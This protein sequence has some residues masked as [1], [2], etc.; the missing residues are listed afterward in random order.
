MTGWV[1]QDGKRV[2]A[3]TGQRAT[4]WRARTV[5]RALD[6]KPHKIERWAT[7]KAKAEALVKA[8]CRDW[9]APAGGGAGLRGGMT[10]EAAAG[11][12][13]EHDVKRSSRAPSTIAQY[14][15]NV[16]R[17]IKGST[18]A[19]LT[20]R[21]A[22]AVGILR[23]YFQGLADGHGFGAADAARKVLAGVLGMAVTDG[24]LPGNAL[25]DVKRISKPRAT[26]DA[27]AD[28]TAHDTRRA[29]T[30]AERARLLEVADRHPREA[31][32]DVSDL[33]H[34][35]AGT[36]VRLGE[37]LECT[38]WGDVDL[39]AGTVLVRGTKTRSAHRTLTLPG[40]LVE[41]LERRANL[42]GTE[43]L[44]FGVTRY[45]SKIGKPRDKRN[46]TRLIEQRCDAAGLP[47]ATSHTFRR[48]VATLMDEAGAPLAEIAN[49][50]GHA[51][52]NT[53]A[54]YLGRRQAPTR[55]ASIL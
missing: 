48:T 31:S 9:Q 11:Y 28:E 23:S 44:V 14:E 12:W 41:R 6:G 39:E 52:T 13:L 35:L 30:R 38:S 53:T 51:D 34:F 46:I 18:I 15:G 55:A 33:I 7:S 36:G 54:G 1:E 4:Q 42:H 5:Y 17:Y 22:N 50:L 25:R 21:E 27:P 37:A 40:W 8:A 10:V 19:G 26:A 47:W 20:L 3:A 16:S 45:E 29:F 43:G 2:P 32:Q 24:A 49:Q